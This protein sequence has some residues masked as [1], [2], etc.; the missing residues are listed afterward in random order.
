MNPAEE[1]RES[2]AQELWCL[3][4]CEDPLASCN[5]ELWDILSDEAD[6]VKA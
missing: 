5:M 1:Y 3:D 6:R 4:T 2:L